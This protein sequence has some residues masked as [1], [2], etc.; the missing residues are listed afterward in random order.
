VETNVLFAVTPAEQIAFN[1]A[2]KAQERHSDARE[3]MV[4]WDK[5]LADRGYSLIG[6]RKAFLVVNHVRGVTYEVI[7]CTRRINK[8]RVA[9]VV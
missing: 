2:I 1:R 7:R 6:S 5:A 9:A 3:V 4:F 8:T